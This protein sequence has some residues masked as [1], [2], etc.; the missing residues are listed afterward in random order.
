M[1]TKV[2][3]VGNPRETHVGRH[4]VNGARQAGIETPVMDVE[5]AYRAPRLIRSLC[6]H[7]LRHRPARLNR[8]NAEVIQ[9]CER[10]Q[11]TLVLA[12]G[13]APLTAPTLQR[14]RS[15]GITT[16]N[17][18]TDDPWNHNHRT[19]WFLPSLHDYDQVF[20]PRRAN[21]PEL[22]ALQGPQIHYLPFAY[23]PEIHHPP[24]PMSDDE[25]H[26]WASEVLFIGG[27]DPDRAAVMRSL[28]SQGLNLSLWGGYWDRMQDLRAY[29]RG[30]AGP[31]AFCKL[32]AGAGVNLCLVRRANR[33]GHS[34]RSF[35]LPA[36]GGSLLVEDT[37]EHREIFGQDG[38]C[39][40]YFS[41][42][43]EMAAQARLLLDDPVMRSR[44]AR[45]VQE[46]IC[47]TGKNSYLDRLLTIV[48][49]C[50]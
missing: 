15:M 4:F 10:E 44:L 9:C 38:E 50:G 37:P 5:E 8:F 1:K 27:A 11:P 31:D 25:K 30:H 7:L 24:G 26:Q 6:W 14:L 12:T 36:V 39:V 48:S 16:A 23:A 41:S 43:G 3:I 17:F 29:A 40:C 18:L 47:H 22:Q 34:M 13:I 20:T 45:N 2:L 21:I 46:R 28:V 49:Q 42:P 32:V 19:T 35:E 33:D